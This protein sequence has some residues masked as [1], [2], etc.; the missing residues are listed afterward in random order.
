MWYTN[1]KFPQSEVIHT[2]PSF[3][4]QIIRIVIISSF[5]A[6][7]SFITTKAESDYFFSYR[8]S[9]TNYNRPIQFQYFYRIIR[10]FYIYCH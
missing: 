6:F 5:F 1:I 3:R 2:E 8:I 9:H 7:V 10:D 4:Y